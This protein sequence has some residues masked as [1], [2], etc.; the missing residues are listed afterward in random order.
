MPLNPGREPFLDPSVRL[1]D[2][3]RQVRSFGVDVGLETDDS[4]PLRGYW[5][6]SVGG[7]LQLHQINTPACTAL[8]DG[9]LIGLQEA[10]RI[11][12]LVQSGLE[13]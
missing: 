6:V 12:V 10:R 1:Y 7:K 8:L 13:L 11:G 2:L 4:L 9:M 3:V 5:R